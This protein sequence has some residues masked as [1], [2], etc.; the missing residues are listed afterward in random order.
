METFSIFTRPRIENLQPHS[1]GVTVLL[2][3]LHTLVEG[4]G[5]A[6]LGPDLVHQD[7]IPVPDIVMIMIMII[8]MIIIQCT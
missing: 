2:L 8:M 6:L 4:G 7:I 3:Q 1:L 5:V